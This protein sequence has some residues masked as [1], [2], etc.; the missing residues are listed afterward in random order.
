[1][2][3]A[4]TWS[5]QGTC[6][7]IRC[8]RRNAWVLTEAPASAVLILPHVFSKWVPD[9]AGKEEQLITLLKLLSSSSLPA[10]TIKATRCR[11]WPAAKLTASCASALPLRA[12]PA[13]LRAAAF[14]FGACQPGPGPP[15]R[16]GDQSYALL[17]LYSGPSRARGRP[18]SLLV[19]QQVGAEA[20]GPCPAA[21]RYLPAAGR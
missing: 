20:R 7:K 2:I 3:K 17:R 5:E 12:L 4:V 19:P 14:R 6:I 15:P 9:R 18:P 11:N 8:V 1:M 10:T 13:P 21:R 16:K